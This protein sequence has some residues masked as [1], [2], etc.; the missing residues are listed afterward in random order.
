MM[1]FFGLIRMLEQS[2]PECRKLR[3]SSHWCQI[4]SPIRVP[5][6]LF[7][8]PLLKEESEVLLLIVSPL[9]KW[10]FIVLSE[11]KPGDLLFSLLGGHLWAVQRGHWLI[12]GV[13]ATDCTDILYRIPAVR[14][15]IIKIWTPTI[16][17]CSPNE[18]PLLHLMGEDHK[19]KFMK[20]EHV[21]W[22]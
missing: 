5:T 20:K 22:L 6:G 7:H 9:Q 8:I 16:Y 2:N 15:K 3:L 13:R 17:P 18:K 11:E 12:L 21:C 10:N 4:L 19:T 1:A 14:T